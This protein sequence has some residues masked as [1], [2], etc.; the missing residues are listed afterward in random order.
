VEP[1]NNKDEGSY[2]A[3]N[4]L[5]DSFSIFKVFLDLFGENKF[6]ET[7]KCAYKKNTRKELG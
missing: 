3:E 1:E 6:F 2:I 5:S 4:V 7:H